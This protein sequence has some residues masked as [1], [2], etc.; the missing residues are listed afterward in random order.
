MVHTEATLKGLNKPNLI[1]LVLQPESEMNSD[2]KELT[3][4]IRDLVAQ[5]KKVEADVAIVKNA[6]EKLVNQLIET[7]RQCWTNAHYSRCECLEVVGIPTSIHN[8][9]LEANISEAFDKLG[10][11]VEGKDIQACHRLKDHDRAIIKLS[12]RKDSLQV[13]RVKKDLKSLDLTEL[14]F[15]EGTKIFINKS[16]CAYYRGLWDKCKKLKGMGK[17]HVFFVPNGTI[18]VKILENDRAQPIT[19]AADLKKMFPD[20]DIDNL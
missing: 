18:K 20:I 19:H 14:Y 8:D 15:P 7:E 5:M 13:L 17:L 12:N 10:V 6:N 1:K 11:H 16:L 2:I 3:S 9:S 4:E